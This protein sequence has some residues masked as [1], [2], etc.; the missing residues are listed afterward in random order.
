[1]TS[2]FLINWQNPIPSILPQSQKSYLDSKVS[3]K[4]KQ[5]ANTSYNSSDVM[6]SWWRNLK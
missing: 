3:D 2:Y 5:L 1:M 6:M 4:I